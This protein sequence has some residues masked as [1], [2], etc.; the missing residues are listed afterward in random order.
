MNVDENLTHFMC[1]KI[2]T[3]IFSPRRHTCLISVNLTKTAKKTR[4]H[5]SSF[6]QEIR[7]AMDQHESLYLF[8]YENMR[9][10]KFKNIRMHFREESSNAKASRIFLGKNKLMQVCPAFYKNPLL[11]FYLHTFK[12]TCVIELPIHRLLWEGLWKKNIQKTYVK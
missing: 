6:V 1:M 8:S 11:A 12:Y 4:D 2:L 7:D 10:H 3:H 9:S 5:K